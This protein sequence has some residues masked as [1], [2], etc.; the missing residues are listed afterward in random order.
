VPPDAIPACAQCGSRALKQQDLSSGLMPGINERQ[1]WVCQRC[2]HIGPEMLFD[3]EEA[4]VAFAD[5]RRTG[6]A[7]PADGDA[8]E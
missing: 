2:G 1:A 3:T 8:G 5:A 7:T 6:D 4:R